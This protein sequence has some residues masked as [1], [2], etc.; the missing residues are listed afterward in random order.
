MRF[1]RGSTGRRHGAWPRT[2]LAPHE[3]GAHRAGRRQTLPSSQSHVR[4]FLD[5][6]VSGRGA[7]ARGRARLY[8]RHAGA[9]GDGLGPAGRLDFHR[10]DKGLL[11]HVAPHLGALGLLGGRGDGREVESN[12][13]TAGAI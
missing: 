1:R 11:L 2:S 10:L 6:P 13:G 5:C 3:G 8:L 12:L 4:A 7:V 9:D